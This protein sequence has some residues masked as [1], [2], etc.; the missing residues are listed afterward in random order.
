M[1]HLQNSKQ[2]IFT[3]SILYRFSYLIQYIVYIKNFS[4]VLQKALLFNIN[5]FRYIIVLFLSG[6]RTMQVIIF[7]MNPSFT[8]I[9]FQ[10]KCFFLFFHGKSLQYVPDSDLLSRIKNLE[11]HSGLLNSLLLKQASQAQ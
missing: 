3:P 1:S 11:A 5:V 6:S 4:I 10:Q 9:Q 2:N 7:R 8:L